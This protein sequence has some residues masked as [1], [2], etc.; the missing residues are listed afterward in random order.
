MYSIQIW[1][2]NSMCIKSG[3]THSFFLPV[4]V[5][6]P[7]N[8]F[9]I[10]PQLA[11]HCTRSLNCSVWKLIT[12]R[13]FISTYSQYHLNWLFTAVRSLSCCVWKLITLRCFVW[14]LSTGFLIGWR[15]HAGHAGPHSL[16]GRGFGLPAWN[17]SRRWSFPQRTWRWG[18]HRGLHQCS[19]QAAH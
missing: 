10:L 6:V 13:C 15:S 1:V 17:W 9:T 19:D 12:V 16:V 2:V 18:Y 11:L 8:I 5:W 4:V 14:K 3:A 7:L